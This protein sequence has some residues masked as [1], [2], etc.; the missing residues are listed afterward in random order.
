MTDQPENINQF[1]ATG[2]TLLG[3]LLSVGVTVAMAST[4]PWWARAT[5]GAATTVGLV[6]AVKLATR[7]GKG[8]VA[9]FARWTITTDR[10]PQAAPAPGDTRPPER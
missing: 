8:P 2:I 5:T 7:T 9:R 3:V 4:G 1:T 10:D 6:L